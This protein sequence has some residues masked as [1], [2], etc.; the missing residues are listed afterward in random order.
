MAMLL[1]MGNIHGANPTARQPAIVV[2][3]SHALHDSWPVR[4][5]LEIKIVGNRCLATGSTCEQA[6]KVGR[7]KSV[8]RW[9]RSS[10]VTRCWLLTRGVQATSRRFPALSDVPLGFDIHIAG[11]HHDR[12][13]LHPRAGEINDGPRQIARVDL[14]IGIRIPLILRI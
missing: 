2:M 11:D 4:L 13:W 14:T 12:L 6:A 8:E 9:P 7:I 10:L 5:G 3:K 1:D